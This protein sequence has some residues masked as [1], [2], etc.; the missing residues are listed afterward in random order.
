MTTGARYD[1]IADWYDTEFQPAPLESETWKTLR[2][3]LGAPAGSLL[4]VGCGTG[5]YAAGLTELGWDVTGVDVSEDMLRRAAAKGVHT[6]HADAAA[7]PFEAESF[8][9]AVSVFTNTDVDDLA[10]VLGEIVRVLRPGAPLVYV[11]VHPCFVGPHSVYDPE[12]KVPELHR[13]WYR[14]VGR[15]TEAPGIWRAAGV[16]IRVG[17]MHLPLGLFLQTFL[18]AGLRLERIEEPEEL[19]YPFGLALRWR[20]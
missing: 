6:V 10:A 1:G 14:H 4:D 20:R 13:G 17:A 18:D 15:Y 2:R 8:D 3:L 19:E 9:A 16:R 12:G 5:A 11:A 7:L